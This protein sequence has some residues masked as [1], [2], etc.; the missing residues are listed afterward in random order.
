[1]IPYAGQMKDYSFDVEVYKSKKNGKNITTKYSNS[2]LT[3]D[4]RYRPHG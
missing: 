2:I 1:M 4:M 3:F